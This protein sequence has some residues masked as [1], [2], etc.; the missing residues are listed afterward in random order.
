MKSRTGKIILILILMLQLGVLIFFGMQKKGMH[1]DECFSYFNT[2]NSFGR[3]A[4]DRTWVSS[5]DIMKDFYVLP[6]EGFNY[7]FV[8]KLQSYDVHPP[9]F[10]ILLHTLCSFMPG[11]FSLWQ[12][13]S[14]NILYA[15]TTTFLLYYIVKFFTDNEYAALAI[16]LI[17]A[18]NPGI[19]TDVMFIRMYC[20]MTLI[21]TGAVFLHIKMEEDDITNIK[22][23]YIVLNAVLAFLGFLTHYFYLVFLFFLETPYWICKL[24]E[25]KKNF[26]IILVY[27]SAI[28]AAGIL[29]VIVYPSCLGHVNSGYR[30]TEVKSYLTDVSD[31]GTRFRFF[32]EL[33]NK[34]IFNGTGYLILLILII[35]LLTAYYIRKTTG[36]RIS[37]KTVSFICCILIPTIGYYL[38]AVKGGLMGDEA[39]MRYVLPAYPFIIAA[40]G[41][42]LYVLIK[43]VIKNVRYQTVILII[44]GAFL[45]TTD[46][47]GAAKGN[48]YYLYKEQEEM[49]E[50]AS[51]NK[52]AVCI[53][54]Y[55]NESQKYLLWNDYASLAQYKKVYFADSQNT[56]AIVD[57]EI[58]NSDRIIV[59][60]STLSEKEDFNDY[61]DLIYK[62]NN[63]IKEY[64]KLGDAMYASYYEFK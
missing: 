2:N 18:L 11:I 16:T 17:Q 51:E 46:I 1:F 31:F 48:V 22:K 55:N 27:G 23:K 41:I 40:V 30:G 59:Y 28:L 21:M 44:L 38:V 58:N 9:V 26:K 4:Y 56:D 7:P 34:Y 25:F 63:N 62:S 14:L 53:Y 10:Y 57:T 54:I 13:L 45:L 43:Y 19:I 37:K 39:M 35:L 49:V 50:T 29:G 24:K 61:A 8:V 64:N 52:D 12:G 42:M 32:G 33:T 15:L 60:V 36:K 6:G 47:I 3:E 5:E 20:L